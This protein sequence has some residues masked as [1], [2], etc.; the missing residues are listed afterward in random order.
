MST[1]RLRARLAARRAARPSR[2][3]APARRS[4]EDVRHLLASAP[5]DFDDEH[6]CWTTIAVGP[7]VGDVPLLARRRLDAL[8]TGDVAP[9]GGA[10]WPASLVLARA[11]AAGRLPVA[12]KRVLE[13]GAGASGVPGLVAAASGAAA[14]ALSDFEPAAVEVLAAN[15]AASRRRVTAERRVWGAGAVGRDVDVVLLADCVHAGEAASRDLAAALRG[16]SAV[17]YVCWE[18]RGL[19]ARSEAAFFSALGDRDARDASGLLDDGDLGRFGL[20]RVAPRTPEGAPTL[21][22]EHAP[23]PPPPP[24]RA[25]D[26]VAVVD[27]FLGPAAAARLAAEARRLLP[28]FDA[29]P[30]TREDHAAEAA[31]AAAIVAPGPADGS[32]DDLARPVDAAAPEAAALAAALGGR[33]ALALYPP[34]SRRARAPA[35]AYYY[36]FEDAPRG[37]VRVFRGDGTA[38]DVAPRADRLLA[39]RGADAAVLPTGAGHLRLVEIVVDDGPVPRRRPVRARRCDDDDPS[40]SNAAASR[41]TT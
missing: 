31:A 14:V 24:P 2:G 9:T 27:G 20:R 33:A 19:H 25:P 41:D 29:R 11:V 17:A 5:P 6:W 15:A 7:P 1:E 13:L 4:V 30:R 23:R 3:D 8:L 10:V 34:G 26:A 28:R 12:G 16:T 21:R 18:R 37:G 38:D 40:D 35:A 32:R 36:F 39:A 22:D